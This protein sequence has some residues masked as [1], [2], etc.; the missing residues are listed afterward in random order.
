M[1]FKKLASMGLIIALSGSILVGCGASKNSK[2]SKEDINL[3][4]NHKTKITMITDDGGINDKSFN[5]NAWEGLQKAKKDLDVEI[6]YIE[7]KKESDYSSNIKKAI[8][9]GSDLIIGTGYKIDKA[10]E[11]A[12]KVNPEQKFALIDSDLGGKLPENVESVMFNSE[13]S[14]YLVGLVAGKLTETNKVG[15][16]GGV[17]CQGV[18]KF[19]AGFTAGV[20]QIN[21]DVEIISKYADSFDNLQKGKILTDEMIT[22]NVDIIF[23]AAGATGNSVIE[24]AKIR[25]KKVI[26]SDID[27]NEVAPETII[28][29]AIK[30]V[31]IG[32]YDAVKNLVDGKFNGGKVTFYGL[33]EGGLGLAPSTKEDVSPD[34]LEF[35][36]QKGDKIKNGEIKVPSSMKDIKDME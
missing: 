11:N 7:T 18:E 33:S 29:S 14:A 30:R 23:H 6:E 9:N 36:N 20:R 24:E 12:S 26:G 21:P 35:I 34:V 10:I 8:D 17:K 2:D 22:D 16:I 15:F 4:K 13:E 32:V 3:E 1:K 27:Q 25:G 19:E 28:T 31:D 5:Q